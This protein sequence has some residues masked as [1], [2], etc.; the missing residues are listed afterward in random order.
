M[1]RLTK[2]VCCKTHELENKR[3][4]LHQS[5]KFYHK[6]CA[7]CILLTRVIVVLSQKMHLLYFAYTSHWSSIT[8]DATLVFACTSHCCSITKD[9][10]FVFC[11]HELLLQ[12]NFNFGSCRNSGYIGTL[13]R[14]V[15]GHHQRPEVKDHLGL[16]RDIRNK[17]W[18][19]MTSFTY[20]FLCI[21]TRINF[22]ICEMKI[23]SISLF[24]II[25]N[26]KT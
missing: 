18:A 23:F 21:P 1:T 20:F 12:Y 16:L 14:V 6:R 5:L 22:F 4:C 26:P 11:L 3:L 8:K 7:F 25:F 10:P 17:K 24:F 9:A 15:L 19:M 13:H 2:Q